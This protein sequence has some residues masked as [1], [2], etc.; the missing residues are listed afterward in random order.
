MLYCAQEHWQLCVTASSEC[1][2]RLTNVG[3]KR[4]SGNRFKLE[5]LTVWHRDLSMGKGV[6]L[7]GS[8]RAS[9][10]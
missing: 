4:P 1:V 9:A 5:A 10:K 7:R 3:P 6:Q 8:E 2:V